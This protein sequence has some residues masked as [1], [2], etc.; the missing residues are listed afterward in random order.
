MGAAEAFQVVIIDDSPLQGALVRRTLEQRFEDRVHVSVYN[1][2]T[3]GVEVLGPWV[4]LL[5]VDWLMPKLDGHCVV[6]RAVRQGVDPK[7]I[8]VSSSHSALELHE[9]F[10]CEGCLAVIEKGEQQ[11][12]AAFMMILD[13]LVRRHERA[14]A[15]PAP[16]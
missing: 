5:L 16:Q 2:P 14:N 7:R 15:T 4:G 1:D 9:E 12:Q 8:I 11:Q 3:V 6:E 10:D 13:G